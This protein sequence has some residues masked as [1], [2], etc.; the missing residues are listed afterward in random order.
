MQILTEAE[1]SENDYNDDELTLRQKP[2]S[3]SLPISHMQSTVRLLKAF[4]LE[5]FIFNL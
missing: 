2:H 3:C 4:S 5:C 1:K